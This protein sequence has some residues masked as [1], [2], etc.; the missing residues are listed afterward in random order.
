M[1]TYNQAAVAIAT[2]AA[3]VPI[4]MWLR[5]LYIA[6]SSRSRFRASRGRVL[7][8][9]QPRNEDGEPIQIRLK[10]EYTVDDRVFQGGRHFFGSLN[11]TD[12]ALLEK[13]PAGSEVIVYYDPGKPRRS[14]LETGVTS[15]LAFWGRVALVAAV[16]IWIATWLLAW[17]V[18]ASIQGG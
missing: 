16:M 18:W 5:T 4:L 7:E 6:S 13:Y 8:H 15:G 3:S 12:A 11:S 2:L 17:G 1:P 10:Y 9:Y 14:T